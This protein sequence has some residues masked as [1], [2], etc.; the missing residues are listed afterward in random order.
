MQVEFINLIFRRFLLRGIQKKDSNLRYGS[1]IRDSCIVCLMLSLT[2][3]YRCSSNDYKVTIGGTGTETPNAVV[4]CSTN[5]VY[6]NASSR[7]KVSLYNMNYLPF[8]QSGFSCDTICNEDGYFKFSN[9][10]TGI[11][12]VLLTDNNNSAFIDSVHMYT[13]NNLK[14]YSVTLRVQGSIKGRIVHDSTSVNLSA[15]YIKGTPFYSEISSDG[16]YTLSGLPSSTYSLFC[17]DFL[18]GTRYQLISV[19][20]PKGLSNYSISVAPG[21]VKYADTLKVNK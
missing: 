5:V 12:N 8:S 10:D 6:G 4:I 17:V 13:N 11:Y 19:H 3:S 15:I 16:Y 1:F 2:F 14:K 9:L 20:T 18:T 21:E 7:V